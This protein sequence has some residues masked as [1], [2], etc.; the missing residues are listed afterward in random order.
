MPPVTPF[1]DRA[2]FTGQALACRRGERLIFSRLDFTLPAGGALLLYGPNGSG[3]SSL[4]RLLAGLTPPA[5]GMLGWGGT[6]IREDRA[7]H[8]ERLHFVGHSDALKPVLSAA[9]SLRFWTRMRGASAGAA[10]A[11]ASFGLAAAADLP[12][13]YLSAGQRRRLAL[14]RL[15]AAPV[16]LWLLD[17]PLTSLDAESIGQLLAA[18]AQHRAAGGRIVLSTHALIE[19]PG[20]ARL[21]LADFKPRMAEVS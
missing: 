18:F 15:M 12:C 7:A 6:D 21:S 16:P 17:E 5:D 10:S 19:L 1:A 3:K 9:E 11:L 8:R 14:A 2:D 20:A 4:L 13:R